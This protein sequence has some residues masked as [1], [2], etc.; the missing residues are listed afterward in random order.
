MNECE[1]R[2]K[3]SSIDHFDNFW[4]VKKWMQK[5]EDR[6]LFKTNSISKL[7]KC[8]TDGKNQASGYGKNEFEEPEKG[9]L[10]QLVGHS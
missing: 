8:D 5:I 3:K 4:N 2:V 9:K 10:N 1:Y 6:P 7:F